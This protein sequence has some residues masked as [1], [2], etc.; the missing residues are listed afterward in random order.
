MAMALL[1]QTWAAGR[2]GDVVALIVDHGLR[3]ESAAEARMTQHR[4][5]FHGIAAQVLTVHGL[6][7]GT[8]LAARAREAR[9]AA[10]T[11]ACA[12]AGILHLLLAHHAADQAE[13]VIMRREAQSGPVG[14]AGMAAIVENAE[15]RLLRP[16]LDIPAGRL[17]A[18]ASVAGL[19]WV[20]DPSNTDPAATR[21]RIR[22]QRCDPDGTGEGTRGLVEDAAAK[23]AA[24]AEQDRETAAAL[25]ACAS[26]H[27]EGFVLLDCDALAPPP[28]AAVIGA[29]GGSLYRPS[30]RDLRGL[31]RGLR[32]M[33]VAG[34][35]VRPAGRLAPG[36]WLVHREAAAVGSAVPAADGAL[37]D[38]RFRLSGT[39]AGAMVAALGADA[40][41][42]RNR[43]DLPAAV[44]S[45]LPAIRR[46]DTLISVPTLDCNGGV[47]QATWFP[48]V[49]AACAPF[50][51]AP[52]GCYAQG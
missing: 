35:Q 23:G 37:W 33:T 7:L 29:V 32:S 28:L 49:P 27:P 16:L 14:L 36:A 3:P 2:G 22:A 44:L 5:W 51:W 21:A 31:R 30:P 41:K 38:G 6:S 15:V 24:R 20:E 43:T 8:A 19:G 46:G 4:L 25:A 40:A 1:A 11:G 17:R 52:A 47:V 48:R 18:T 39:M 50:A 34:V 42:V 10:L 45:T 13:T 9:Y 26:F 12:S